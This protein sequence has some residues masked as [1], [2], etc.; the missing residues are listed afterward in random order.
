MTV[1]ADGRTHVGL[2]RKRNEDAHLVGRHLLAVADGLGGHVAGDVASSTAIDAVRAFD[3]PIA[4]AD[5]A[6]HLGRAVAAAN[7][8]LLEVTSARP[9]C[10]GMGTTL[11]GLAWAGNIAIV[12]NIGDSRAY[13]LRGGELRQISEDH[14]YG[15]LVG[16]AER[17]PELPGRLSR[18]L[19]GRRD[20]RSPDLVPL[21]VLPGDRLLLCSDGLSNPVPDGTI[22]AALGRPARAGD[23]AER[24]VALA[25]ERGGPDNVTV[26]VADVE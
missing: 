12:V 22:A 20:G 17:V 13:L 3:R 10:A 8:A 5:L 19:D 2:V 26:V 18:F 21:V 24:L 6:V 25:L 9:E 23:V 15:N 11:V 7:D 16:G 14:V 1:T 4:P